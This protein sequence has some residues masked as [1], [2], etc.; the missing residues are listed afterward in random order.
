MTPPERILGLDFSGAVDAGRGIWLAEGQADGSRLRVTDCR[1]AADLP[2]GGAAREPALAALR[3]YLSGLGAYAIGMDFPFSL[4]RSLV[5]ERTLVELLAVFAERYPTPEIFR[6]A[7]RAA[8]SERA[9]KRRCDLEARTPFAPHNLWLYRQTWHGIAAL[10]AP[11]SAGG[12]RILP[13]ETPLGQKPWLLETC[14]ASALKAAERYVPYKGRTSGHRA[15]REAILDWLEAGGVSLESG[16]RRD[17]LLDD[18]GGDA[19]DS[20][21]CAWIVWR[22]VNDPGR[23]LPA[24]GPE[25]LVEGYVYY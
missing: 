13:V 19:L 2:G 25:H 5:P 14:P 20:V 18:A 17:T 22:A 8:G 11:L 1:R 7:C 12:A 4:H 15:G 9:L 24:L 3:Q 21:I 16:V 6:E 10:L 23:L